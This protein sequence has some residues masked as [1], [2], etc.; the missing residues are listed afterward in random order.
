MDKL[1]S[2]YKS[3]WQW[4]WQLAM[5][6]KNWWVGVVVVLFLIIIWWLWSHLTHE[7]LG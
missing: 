6:D 4:G 2:L 1:I 5:G 3:I 7:E